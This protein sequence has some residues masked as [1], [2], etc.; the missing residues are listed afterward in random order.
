MQLLRLFRFSGKSCHL[1]AFPLT[2]PN[3][4]AT[5][6]FNIC[7]FFSYHLF[8]CSPYVTGGWGEGGLHFFYLGNYDTF[9]SPHTLAFLFLSK[10]FVLIDIYFLMCLLLWLCTFAC[11]LTDP[12]LFS[13]IFFLFLFLGGIRFLFYFVLN[14]IVSMVSLFF[15]S[16]LHL[17]S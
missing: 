15:D 9:P 5:F 4:L 2:F 7:V 1:M 16:L 14:F 11:P 13:I 3:D 12:I 10:S 6:I 17:S 8:I